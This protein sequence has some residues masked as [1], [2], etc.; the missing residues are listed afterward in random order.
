MVL[1]ALALALAAAS[2]LW[3]AP[4]LLRLPPEVARTI[5]IELRLPRTL[6]GL[7]IGASLALAGAALQGLLRNPLASPDLLGSSTGAA[8]GAVIAAYWLGIGG[9]LG[10]ALGG[11]TGALLA[12]LLLLGLAGRGASTAT[13]VLAGVAISALAAALTNLALSLAPSPFALYDVLFWLLG[14]LADR[15][16]EQLAF[17]LPAMLAG[18]ALILRRAR[19][20][21]ALALGEDVAETLG[22]R[23]A[24]LRRDIVVG[25]ALVVGAG[26]AVAGSI[27]FVGLVVPHLVRPLVGHS[28]GR[29]L[30][31]SALAGA[32]LLTAADLAVRIP[33]NGQELKLGVLTALLGAPFFLWLVL[34]GRRSRP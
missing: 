2:L 12:L 23:V 33:V 34:A 19:A 32:A 20:L 5:F 24:T 7:A 18:A 10:L 17:A 29:A 16:R 8:L 25:A 4:E 9:T 11:M 28:P 6:L 21:D 26:V 14:S 22:V 27:G 13:L 15:S 1:A 30:V 31:P 3:N